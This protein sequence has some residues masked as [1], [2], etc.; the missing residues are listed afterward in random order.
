MDEVAANGSENSNDVSGEQG[1]CHE[2]RRCLLMMIGL[3]LIVLLIVSLLAWCQYT[4]RPK[5]ERYFTAAFAE[6]LEG[7]T[8]LD[9]QWVKEER[10]AR[11]AMQKYS[12]PYLMLKLP[13]KQSPPENF[14][15][16]LPVNVSSF[17]GEAVV[18]GA[19]FLPHGPLAVV[20]NGDGC[21]GIARDLFAPP[22]YSTVLLS[23]MDTDKWADVYVYIN[24]K[25]DQV[26]LYLNNR[27]ILTSPMVEPTYPVMEVWLGALWLQ[28]AGN[29]GAPL[30]IKYREI[31]LG[32]E[33]LLPQPTYWEFLWNFILELFGRLLDLLRH[34][35]S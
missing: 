17:T 15:W 24:G 30:D 1:F 2:K 4:A 23:T 3:V 20:V 19:V 14:V 6:G 13:T 27:R 26:E 21:L 28:G 31:T 5:P 32:N 25:D 9:A 11:L 22:E 8:K 33:G 7:W 16:H 29:Y 12:A 18:L 10:A 34:V 35:I